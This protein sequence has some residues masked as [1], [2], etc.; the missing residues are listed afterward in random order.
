MIFKRAVARLRAQDWMAIGIEIGIVI[1]GVF[2]GTQV[3]N[4]NN[5]R[6]EQAKTQQMARDLQPELRN[7]ARDLRIMIAYYAT[8]R[9][10][11]DT[12]FAGWRDDPRVSDRD[13]VIAAYQSSQNVLTGVNNASWSQIFGSD[14]LRDLQNQRLR[15]S[16]SALMTTDLAGF[17][18][19]LSTE[20]RRDVRMAIPEDIQDAIRAHC[21]DRRT[22]LATIAL[23]PT[24]TLDLPEARFTAAAQALRANPK[25]VGELRYH[26]AV[27]ASYV[28]TIR[29]LHDLTHSALQQIT[30]A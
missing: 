22:G 10:Y 30:R 6:I 3:S 28:E 11:G 23:P 26:F 14:R 25:L 21:G 27:V 15:E 1:I 12:A 2:I 18:R 24:C 16:L 17:E 7:L 8:A 19:D 20:Y 29:F 9:R 4:L 13:F 5:A